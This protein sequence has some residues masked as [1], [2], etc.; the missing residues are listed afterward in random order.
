MPFHSAGSEFRPCFACLDSPL[1]RE[2]TW[3]GSWGCCWLFSSHSLK[4]LAV[5]L[6][7]PLPCQL[8]CWASLL[9]WAP[10]AVHI[11][12][13]GR[14]CL[15]Y[16]RP[17]HLIFVPGCL[18]LQLSHFILGRH[19][20][21]LTGGTFMLRPSFDLRWIIVAGFAG[22]FFTHDG[23]HRHS[24]WLNCLL[25][26]GG[27]GLAHWRV[28]KHA[29]HHCICVI[30]LFLEVFHPFL[31]HGL[32][33]L[34]HVALRVKHLLLLNLFVEDLFI[35]R[36]AVFLVP[37]DVLLDALPDRCALFVCRLVDWRWSRPLAW[38]VRQSVVV[39]TAPQIL[40]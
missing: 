39:G 24:S 28:T 21:H 26:R 3:A 14:T 33:H 7:H 36:L 29:D 12:I 5:K 30:C 2:Q 16:A 31:V 32:L 38:R 23:S 37:I 11:V 6:L 13:L 4:S 35:H 34:C 18:C 25:S 17:A 20:Q 22:A 1:A 40:T 10:R 27:L 9:E 8:I 19:E 15:P